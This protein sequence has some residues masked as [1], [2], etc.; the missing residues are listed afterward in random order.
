MDPLAP[1]ITAL[2][3]EGRLR[4]WSLVITVFGDLVQHRGGQISTA[5]LGQLLGRVGVE[6][7]ALRTALS[8]LGHDGW[9]TRER[10][11]RT[12]IYRLSAQGL[13]R[14]AP[15]TTRIYAAPRT[16]PVSQ[17][18]VVV[19]L[20][21]NDGQ[22]VI[23]CPAE[24]AP[25]GG[26]CR[27]VGSLAQVSDAYRAALVSPAHAGALGALD[28][29]LQALQAGVLTSPDAA[30]ARM[31]LIHRWRRIVLRFSEIPAYLMPDTVALRDPRLSVARAY[32][33]LVPAAERWLDTAFP[34]LPSMPAAS[35]G[36]AQ[37]FGGA[38]QT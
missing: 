7:G 33:R 5:R 26:D 14:F 16:A 34:G 25:R 32:G 17:W 11:G 35:A 38:Q 29:D 22:S 27:V 24:N 30:A 21:E 23:L 3:S 15:A 12:S 9:V 4:V 6:K 37:R 31:L 19:T 18:A 2:H 20:T 8:R 13:D 10:H 1:L 28:A 36:F